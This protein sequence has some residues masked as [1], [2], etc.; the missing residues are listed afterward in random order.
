M[1]TTTGTTPGTIADAAGGDRAGQLHVSDRFDEIMAGIDERAQVLR[2]AGDEND[3]LGKPTDAAAKV[4]DELGVYRS[5]LPAPIGG[6]EFSPRQ[7]VE[8]MEALAW[9]DS[10]T[11]WILLATNVASAATGAFAAGEAVDE[12]F[13]GGRTARLAGQGTRQGTARRVDGGYVISGYWQYNSGSPV[14]THIHTGIKGDDGRNLVGVLPI[15]RV[16]L[17]DNWDV[18]G[19]RATGSSD[20]RIDEQFVPDAF[21]YEATS[22]E[23]KRGGAL[24][25]MGLA[26]IANM[27][28]G[29]WA[30]GACK[31]LLEEM[32]AVAADKADKPGTS[33]QTDQFFAEYADL[34]VRY[35]AARA[36][37]MQTWA[38]IEASLDAGREL[39]TEQGTLI[40]LATYNAKRTAQ[41]IAN[42]VATWAGT[43]AM[44]PGVI[45]RYLRDV[46]TG[47]QHLLC[48]PPIH[49]AAGKQLAGLAH[50]DAQWIFYDLVEPVADGGAA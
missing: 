46:Y 34:D 49:Q 1:T 42:G 8:L 35:R 32:R 21:T 12:L 44:R 47:V 50:P 20:Y 22:R 17:I 2:D 36:F 14:A 9:H 18:L 37:M 24:Y 19:L 45:Q 33:T 15:D 7:L 26:N 3:R 16:T 39:T 29:G 40:L 41:A 30:L 25:R 48:S 23:P 11:G 6:L 13:G 31:R 5:T 28:H 10:S 43:T 4:L 38:D 27:H